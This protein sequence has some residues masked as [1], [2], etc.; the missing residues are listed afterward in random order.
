MVDFEL[1]LAE[2]IVVQ[3]RLA[4]IGY[5]NKYDRELLVTASDKIEAEIQAVQI[6]FGNFKRIPPS[7][8]PSKDKL[9]ASPDAA[10]GPNFHPDGWTFKDCGGSVVQV[11]SPSGREVGIGY[12]PEGARA[13]SE[14]LRELVIEVLRANAP[15][16]A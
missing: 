10:G 13:A 12:M 7:E 3:R 2:A 8:G 6:R 9:A 14:I 4:Q 16:E 5:P 15:V 1:T 11:R